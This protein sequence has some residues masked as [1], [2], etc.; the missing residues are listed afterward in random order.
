M[1]CLGTW[2]WG[3]PFGD[4][5][6]EG[7]SVSAPGMRASSP[8]QKKNVEALSMALVVVLRRVGV[9]SSRHGAATAHSPLHMVLSPN[10]SGVPSGAIS[11]AG[12]AWVA[13]RGV[14]HLYAF[15][16]GEWYGCL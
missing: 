16:D 4:L 6:G 13:K 1:V 9:R 10:L 7:G 2:S 12:K 11:Q 8:E 5:T 3:W 14:G 15:V